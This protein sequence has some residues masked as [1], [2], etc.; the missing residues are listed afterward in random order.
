MQSQVKKWGNSL[1]IRI[2][3][4]M[5]RELDLENGSTVEITQNEN[6]IL[7]KTAKKTELLKKLASIKPENLHD[8]ISYGRQEGKEIW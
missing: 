6:Q 2:P 4:V 3:S 1:G 7:I 8:E 5:A